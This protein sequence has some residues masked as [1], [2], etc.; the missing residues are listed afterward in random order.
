MTGIFENIIEIDLEFKKTKSFNINPDY[1]KDYIGGAS[2]AARLFFDLV[3]PAV[4]PLAEDNPLFL[5]CG[6]LVGTNFPGS[7]RFVMCAN[8]PL[9]GIWGE[10][11]SGGFFGARLKKSRD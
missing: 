4:D 6:P 5:M 2:L 8:S 7:S 3:D 1:I 9:T 10:S 11:A